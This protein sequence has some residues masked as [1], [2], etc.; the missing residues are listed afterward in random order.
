MT[1]EVC[2]KFNRTKTTLIFHAESFDDAVESA[3]IAIR[4]INGEGTDR[5]TY[6]DGEPVEILS[7][8]KHSD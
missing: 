2:Y 8:K 5:D 6:E 1:W 7:L 3:P 4:L